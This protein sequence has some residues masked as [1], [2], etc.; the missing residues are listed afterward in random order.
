ME[1]TV[2]I[3]YSTGDWYLYHD[4]ILGS[5]GGDRRYSD[6]KDKFKNKRS[7]FWVIVFISRN[8]HSRNFEYN[9]AIILNFLLVFVES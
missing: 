9:R 1:F 6:K 7:S 8:N 5:C 4:N 3:K 2:H